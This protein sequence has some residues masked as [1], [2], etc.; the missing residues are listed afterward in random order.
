MDPVTYMKINHPERYK[1]MSDKPPYDAVENPPHYAQYAIQPIEFIMA[2]RLG[3]CEG[4]VVKY[5]SRWRMKDGVQDLEKARNYIN[6]LIE[7]QKKCNSQSQ[8]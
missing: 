3:Y 1:A 5:I 8:D 4:N 7:E 6:I 2:N